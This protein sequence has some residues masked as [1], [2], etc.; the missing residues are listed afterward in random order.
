MTPFSQ[1]TLS[2]TRPVLGLAGLATT[3]TSTSQGVVQPTCVSRLHDRFFK[4][5]S[6][7]PSASRFA[8]STKKNPRAQWRDLKRHIKSIGLSAALRDELGEVT[9]YFKVRNL[10]A[11]A[12]IMVT[13]VAE[14]TQVFRLYREKGKPR[15]ELVTVDKL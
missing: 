2:S 15:V 10:A 3:L 1:L 12:G 11:H 5:R 9:R 8:Q 6:R 4:S 7:R 14:A 13:A